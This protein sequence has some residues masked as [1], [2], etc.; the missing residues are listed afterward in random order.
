MADS[1]ARTVSV[2]LPSDVLA[3]L[4]AYAAAE[5][6]SR[7]WVIVKAIKRFLSEERDR[8]DQDKQAEEE[9]HPRPG[10]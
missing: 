5:E 6:R 10:R 3:E 8:R 1:D 4:D 9:S 7:S 2:W